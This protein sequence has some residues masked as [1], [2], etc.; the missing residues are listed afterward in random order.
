MM[1]AVIWLIV[2]ADAM[3][4]VFSIADVACCDAKN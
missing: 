1:L 3:H 4:V 2:T